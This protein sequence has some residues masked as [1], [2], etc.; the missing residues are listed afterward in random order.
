MCSSA[1]FPPNASILL[2]PEATLDWLVI[3]KTPTSPVLLIWVPPHSST[4]K[5]LSPMLNTLTSS[6]Y[7]SPNNA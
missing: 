2:T 1:F 7:F 5:D 6:S 3:T 4:E